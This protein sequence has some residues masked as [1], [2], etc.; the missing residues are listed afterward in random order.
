MDEI[1]VLK[2]QLTCYFFFF[3]RNVFLF[4]GHNLQDLRVYVPETIIGNCFNIYRDFFASW[5]QL[6]SL[7]HLVFRRDLPRKLSIL[8]PPPV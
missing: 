4:R 8:K 2:L 6:K 5:E 7:F 3:F 1:I